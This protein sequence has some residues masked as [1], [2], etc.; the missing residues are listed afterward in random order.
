MS[1][2]QPSTLFSLLFTQLDAQE[3]LTVLHI[4]SAIPETVEFFSQFRSKLYF[5]DLFSELPID[6]DEEEG[7]S[8]RTRL[9]G[10]VDFPEA[11]RFD[12]CLFW[13]VFNYLDGES[14]TIFLELLRPHLSPGS[15]AHAFAVYNIKSPQGDEIYGIRDLNSLNVRSRGRRLPGYHPHAQSK[16]KTLLAGFNVDRSVLLANSRLELLLSVNPAYR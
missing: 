10:L 1:E 2:L 3:R 7:A 5:L 16:L 15:L 14:I 11:V 4:G 12:L 6:E 8:R 9:A 13:D